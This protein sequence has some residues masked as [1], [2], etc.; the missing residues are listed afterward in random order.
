MDVLRQKTELLQQ[1]GQIPR[2]LGRYT[3]DLDIAFVAE[4]ILD[5]LDA[6][7]V[8]DAVQRDIVVALERGQI[9]QPAADP[10]L[11]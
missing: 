3:V 5:K 10:A 6:A 1:V 2:N 8:P 9:Q 7:G 11:N 4:T